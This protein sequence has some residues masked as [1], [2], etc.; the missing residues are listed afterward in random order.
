[1]EKSTPLSIDFFKTEKNDEQNKLSTMLS[2]P[3][4]NNI[5]NT[6]NF[7]SKIGKNNNLFS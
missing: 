7:D 5:Y 2:D 3:F 1:M 4:I 6:H